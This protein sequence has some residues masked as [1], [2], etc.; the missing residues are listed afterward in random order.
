[1]SKDTIAGMWYDVSRVADW[2]LVGG[3]IGSAEHM[4]W[5]KEQ[6]VTTVINAACEVSDIRLCEQHELG[7]YHMYWYDDQKHKSP[8]EFL[9]A[10]GWVRDEEA[11]L[12]E[13][14]KPLC[15]YVHCQMGINR[16]PLLATFLLA[17]R[18][19][20]SAD[21]AW[22]RIKA[23]RPIATSFGKPVYREACVRALREHNGRAL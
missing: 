21:E 18:D 16:G 1:M 8:H 5:L 14:G 3:E 4:G 9:H 20:L 11:K 15:L 2:L 19:G 13:V 22:D 7:Y 12:A 10:L 6:G 17:A 23:A